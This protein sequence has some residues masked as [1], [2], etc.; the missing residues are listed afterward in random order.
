VA[1]VFFARWATLLFCPQTRC[2]IIPRT[3]ILLWQLRRTCR[4]CLIG[5]SARVS[6]G[7]WPRYVGSVP[8]R[9]PNQRHNFCSGLRAILRDYFGLNGEPPVYDEGESE[10][11][12]RV[13]R[14]VFLRV[15]NAMKDRPFGAAHHC[16]RETPSPSLAKG[17]SRVSSHCVW[18]RA[19]QDR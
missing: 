11:R 8:G 12:F 1:T 2:W 15:Y 18:R 9:R 5:G 4:R 14:S 10:R 17:G 7:C 19:V 13:P 6:L 16:H 3:C